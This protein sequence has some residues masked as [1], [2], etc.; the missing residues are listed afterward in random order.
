MTSTTIKT[1]KVTTTTG[2]TRTATRLTLEIIY[3]FNDTN[4]KET[5][6][7]AVICLTLSMPT[8]PPTTIRIKQQQ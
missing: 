7:K 2:A 5:T 4:N 6:T 3:N 8:I 1:T